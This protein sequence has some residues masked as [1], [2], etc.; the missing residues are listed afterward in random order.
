MIE[1]ISEYAVGQRFIIVIF[2]VLL[3]GI[4][5]YAAT[6][7][8]IDAF[9]DVTNVQ[10]Q[11]FTEV[12]TLAAVEVEKL[13]SFPV[14]SV[15]N[16]ITGVTQVRSISKNGLSIITVVFKDSTDI[17]FARQQV[18]ERLKLAEGRLPPG[19]AE[20]SMGP[21][22]TGMGQIYQYVVEGQGKSVMDLRTVQDWDAKFQLR[23]VPGVTDVLSFGGLVK[24]YQVLVD[25]AKLVSY[26]VH[27]R[28]VYEAL[29]RNN[30]NAGG[31]F[32]EHGSEQY[33]VRGVG[34]ARN[35]E[36]I[37]NTVIRSEGGT[38]I[39]V[40]NVAD[41]VVGPE[42]RQ[43]AVSMN[44]KGEVVTGI[45]L[46]LAGE[47]SRAVINRVKQKVEEVNKSLPAGVKVN[48]YY[49][50][51][52]LVEKSVGTVKD[53]LLEGAI[54]VVLVLALFLGNVRS[55][56]IVTLTLPASVLIAFALMRLQGMSANLM[57]LGG[58]AVGIGMMVDGSVVMVE[59]IFRHLTEPEGRSLSLPEVVIRAAREVARPITFAIGIIVV[60]FLP[61]FTL[62]GYEGKMFTPMAYTIAFAML[63]SLLVSL[64]LAPVLCTFL[65]KKGAHEWENPLLKGFR[66]VYQPILEK[67]MKGR[68][69]AVAVA[70]VVLVVSLAMV[71]R[72][73][74]EFLPELD[75]G[76]VLVRATMLPSVSLDQSL[77]MAQK[78][79]KLLLGVPDVTNV[80][81]RI[82]RAE[83]GGD[84]EDISNAELY[85]MLKPREQWKA[86]NKE[87]LVEDMRDRLSKMPGAVYSFSQP[88]ATRVDELLS[89]VKA[90]V[91][92][93]VFGPDL[94]VLTRKAGEIQAAIS[95][96]RGVADLQVEQTTGLAQL[97]IDID[98]NAIA[99]YGISVD[100]VKDVI[101]TAIGGK[102]A[103]QVFEGDRRI[104]VAVRLPKQQREDMERIRDLQVQAPGDE[105]IP[106]SQ[107]AAITVQEGPTAIQREDSRR[108]VVVQCNVEGRDMGGFVADA[109]K[110]IAGQVTLPAGYYIT[111]GGQ[112][113]SQQR[114]SARLAIVVPITILL[115]FL[116][117]FLNFG[118]LRNALLI[119]LNL[120]FALIGGIWALYLRDMHMS[121]S[122]SV[123]FIALFGVAVLNGVVMVTCFNQLRQEGS[124]V[125]DA[126]F[127]GVRLRLRP[128]IMTALVAS[129][130]LVPLMFSGGTGSEVQK[131]LATVVV[132]GLITSTLL[133]LFLLPTLYAWWER[134][135]EV[136]VDVVS[137]EGDLGG[138]ER[139]VLSV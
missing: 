55:A 27:L 73:G 51:S 8:P 100:D 89:G 68:V 139:E 85:V 108:R 48:S 49:D 33:I 114:A 130:G 38:P 127:A 138:D 119:V 125:R 109:Q 112:F 111:W 90:Q 43:G 75:E 136:G 66:K 124:T 20:P 122:A 16:G 37:G 67:T 72:L 115:I 92:V 69:A 42:V 22:S 87:I 6:S 59:N 70:V 3:A 46:Q 135:V 116:L 105:H 1:R 47:N 25:P 11:V 94:E 104:D 117:L 41:I 23:T 18:F 32:I 4:G 132:G 28:D 80:L 21:V 129:L 134:D 78:M 53:A 74:S 5:I 57:S 83:I 60:V 10:V 13:I 58:L 26:H 61:L 65:L 7:L 88:I 40:R 12:P 56:L 36:E 76:S 123:G 63:G 121:V 133:T 2:A 84:P 64:T 30:S 17:Y 44:G 31:G 118:S 98:R 77:A 50:Q 34:L 81:S 52:E 71:P 93:K 128:V 45:V 79:E 137:E 19:L 24:Q 54:L 86:R 110:A 120:P 113:E 99:R 91:A 29:A 62:Q 9:P 102:V 14:E 106:L 107:I 126:V 131:P 15:M 39:F 97:N 95:T 96:V 35:R 103:T 82:G 101:E